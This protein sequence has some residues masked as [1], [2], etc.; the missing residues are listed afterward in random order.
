MS[1][2]QYKSEDGILQH[3]Q[4]NC[5]SSI[6]KLKTSVELLSVDSGYIVGF[7]CAFTNTVIKIL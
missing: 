2:S 5:I 6:I 4:G 1:A 3:V 7:D